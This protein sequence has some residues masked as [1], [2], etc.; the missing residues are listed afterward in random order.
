MMKQIQTRLAPSLVEYLHR[1]VRE[2]W[3]E[4]ESE[5]LRLIVTERALRDANSETVS[6]FEYRPA[7]V[8]RKASR[9]KG[10]LCVEVM[11]RPV[12]EAPV[13]EVSE[14][15]PDC[16]EDVPISEGNS[17]RKYPP[18]SPS[19]YWKR[20]KVDLSSMSEEEK[21]QFIAKFGDDF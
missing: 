18:V 12:K 20:H 10:R 7:K 13:S 6:P 21:A 3:A 1:I 16:T 8:P 14:T 9:D 4:S 11:E 19:E 17:E 2:G 5:A 15:V